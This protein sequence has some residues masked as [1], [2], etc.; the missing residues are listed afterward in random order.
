MSVRVESFGALRNY[1]SLGLASSLDAFVCGEEAE[2]FRTI[3]SS[4]HWCHECQRF[5]FD[6]PNME[7]RI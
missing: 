5:T 4:Y 1:P 6:A 7:I 3:D 2:H